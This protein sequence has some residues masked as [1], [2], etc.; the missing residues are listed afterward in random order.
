MSCTEPLDP[1]L[2]EHYLLG[3]LEPPRRD[4]LEEHLFSCPECAD[5]VESLQVLRSALDRGGAR[6]RPWV[7]GAGAAAALTVGLGLHLLR[8]PAGPPDG[9]GE[10]VPTPEPVTL[11]SLGR[12]DPPS[13]EPRRL[14]GADE[15]QRRFAA[16]MDAYVRGDWAAALPDLAEA[17]RLDPS[18]PA[19]AFFAGIC[20]TLEGDAEAGALTLGRVADLGETAYLE[21][22]LFY[23]AKA[24]LLDSDAAG[25]RDALERLAALNGERA[26]G[27]RALLERLDGFTR[28]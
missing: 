8:A 15:A 24:R 13:Y 12:F 14:R 19:P 28:E 16:G 9:G 18:A 25:A 4:E 23:L 1:E 27:A 5:R 2:L 7:L 22:A 20:R 6:R 11:A 17:E 10:I 3:R 26:A 21:D